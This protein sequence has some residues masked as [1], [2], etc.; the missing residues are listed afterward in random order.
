M[1]GSIS[2]HSSSVVSLAY[3][4]PSRRYLMRVISVHD[5]LGS[6]SLSAPRQNHKWLESLNSIFG[7]PLSLARQEN[8]GRGP[9]AW[10]GSMGEYQRLAL[11][12][13]SIIG[14]LLIVG[15][16]TGHAAQAETKEVVA[17]VAHDFYPEYMV[18]ADGHPGGSGIDLMDAVAKRAGLSVT[19]RVFDAWSDL[20]AALER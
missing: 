11:L 14:P 9:T 16:T 18:D 10:E 12:V 7:H 4:S 3:R 13:F 15:A 8:Q 1:C 19:Y 17:A 2:A 20:I 5:I 6:P